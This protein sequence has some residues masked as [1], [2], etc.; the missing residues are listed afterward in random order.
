MSVCHHIQIEYG[1]IAQFLQKLLVLVAEVFQIL[2]LDLFNGDGDFLIAKI[3]FDAF[4]GDDGGTAVQFHL[5]G[6]L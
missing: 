4:I 2:G 6:I 1:G 3:V 5:F